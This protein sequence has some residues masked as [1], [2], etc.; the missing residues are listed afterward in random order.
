MFLYLL[1]Y[2][3]ILNFTNVTIWAYWM[4]LF[5]IL[6]YN[7]LN[8]L[9]FSILWISWREHV[10]YHRSQLYEY[11][12]LNIFN[13]IVLNFMN[14]IIW[15]CSMSPFLTLIF[16]IIAFSTLR[17]SWHEHIKCYCSQLYESQHE[18]FN[19]IVINFYEY[20]NMNICNVIVNFT[21]IKNWTYLMLS[22]PTVWISRS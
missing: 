1:Y 6:W 14:I 8:I 2:I 5:S 16:N 20:H 12:D 19:V 4:L 10:Q 22:F 11:Q 15:T 7:N 17:I 13:I 18:H 3:I 9:L 21:N